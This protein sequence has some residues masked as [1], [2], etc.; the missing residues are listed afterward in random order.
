MISNRICAAGRLL[1]VGVAHAKAEAVRISREV[2]YTDAARE[3]TTFGT[4]RHKQINVK[5]K[6]DACSLS[7]ISAIC[8]N[9]GQH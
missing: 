9:L 8:S 5:K 2:Y 7:D 1:F 4:G 6:K 3:P